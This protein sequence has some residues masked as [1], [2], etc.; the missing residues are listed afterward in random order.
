M[1]RSSILSLIAACATALAATGCVGISDQK[2]SAQFTGAW[3]LGPAPARC[4]LVFFDNGQCLATRRSPE[5]HALGLRGFWRRLPDGALA[6]MEDGSAVTLKMR[7]RRVLWR[8]G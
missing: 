6:I 5:T 8:P 1:N 2:N 4:E 7:G 3:I